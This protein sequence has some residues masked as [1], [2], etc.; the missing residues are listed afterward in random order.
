MYSTVLLLHSWTR[1]LVLV[2]GLIAIFRAFSGW[3][4]RKPFVGADNGMGAAFVGSMHLQ[5]LL[6]LILYF[7][8]SPFGMKAFETAGG[9]VMKD[10]TGRF[11][12]VEHLVGM[13]LA[14]VAAQVGRTLSKKTIDP[15]LKHKKAFTWFLIAL[16][17]VL[18]MIP[19]GI[20]NPERPAFRL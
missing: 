9:A 14:V 10:P 1:W 18:V 17:L 4:G 15:V 13:L 8:L 7:G 19:W 2:F 11:W 6:G 3:Q 5:L 20:W 12:G 16:L